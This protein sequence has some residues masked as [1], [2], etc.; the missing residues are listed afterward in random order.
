MLARA[1]FPQDV[2]RRALAMEAEQAE[3]LVIKLRR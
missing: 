3:A 1:G 2:A